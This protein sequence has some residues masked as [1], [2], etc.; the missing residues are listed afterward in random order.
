MR[1]VLRSASVR[2]SVPRSAVTSLTWMW[3][4]AVVAGVGLV[5]ADKLPHGRPGGL[6]HRGGRRPPGGVVRPRHVHL[7]RQHARRSGR[8]DE[9]CTLVQRRRCRSARDI[10]SPLGRRPLS[11]G[12]AG[13][14]RR[15]GVRRPL[16]LR[17]RWHQLPGRLWGPVT[18]IS[19]SPITTVQ[20][21]VPGELVT[22]CAA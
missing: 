4:L 10:S 7:C 20:W 22:A 13:A 15:P 6:R 8:P 16:A 12:R 21:R 5:I 3:L 1:A 17:G 19:P 11:S 9:G 14:G 18:G 2:S